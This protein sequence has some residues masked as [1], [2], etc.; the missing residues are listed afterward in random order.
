MNLLDGFRQWLTGSAQA[1]VSVA[2]V[3]AYILPNNPEVL[4]AVENWLAAEGMVMVIAYPRDGPSS[5]TPPAPP[6]TPNPSEPPA[7]AL[8]PI[9]ALVRVRYNGALYYEPKTDKFYTRVLDHSQHI[10]QFVKEDW[11]KLKSW[12]PFDVWALT[13]DLEI[14]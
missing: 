1:R 9:G 3:R 2:S 14:A 12:P 11:R 13:D 4:K 10:V 7:P 5:P 6:E 8:F